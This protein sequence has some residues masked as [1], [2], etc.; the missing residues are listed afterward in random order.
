M[1]GQEFAYEIIDVSTWERRDYVANA[2]R[3]GRAFILGDSAHQC[4]PTGG[5]GMHTGI[6]EAVNLAWKLS[7]LC[8]G[9]GGGRLLDSFEAEC[10]PIAKRLVERST[11][12]FNAIA[13]LP[14]VG[15]IRDALADRSILSKLNVPEQV[16]AQFAYLNSP[17]CVTDQQPTDDPFSPLIRPGGRAPHCWLEDGR[18]TI[19]LFGDLF[20]LLR[21]GG[22]A[23]DLDS[24]VTV[25]AD[26]GVPLKI[27]DIK[28][29][30]VADRFGR[31]L[32]LIRPDSHIAWLGDVVPDDAESLIDH[33][34]G[35]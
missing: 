11:Q 12:T 22:R 2:Y 33:V 28:E 25:A 24:L 35:A 27:I 23:A 29:S 15:G 34:R 32:A 10:R 8:A 26:R 4:S 19:D 17:I 16:K 18:S 31:N 3:K 14:G 20:V 30:D 6:C 5:L 7:A 13:D 9:W 1:L 21:M